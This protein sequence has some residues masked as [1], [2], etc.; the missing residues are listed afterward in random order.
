V[1]AGVNDSRIVARRPGSPVVGVRRRGGH[2]ERSECVPGVSVDARQRDVPG[3]RIDLRRS[4]ALRRRVQAPRECPLVPLGRFACYQVSAACTFD[5]ASALTSTVS[6]SLTRNSEARQGAVRSGRSHR[7]RTGQWRR[8]YALGLWV[9]LAREQRDR[10]S[11]R[12]LAI[13]LDVGHRRLFR[14]RLP[15][16]HSDSRRPRLR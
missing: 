16:A 8:E 9:T 4:R 12:Q 6:G 2:R 14:R 3:V 5:A 15:C 13:Y 11:F 7:T 1:P 10:R